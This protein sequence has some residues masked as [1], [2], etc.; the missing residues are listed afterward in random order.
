MLLTHSACVMHASCMPLQ[1]LEQHQL[2]VLRTELGS[3][4]EK[5]SSLADAYSTLRGALVSIHQALSPQV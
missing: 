1:E 5:L 4:Q 3:S 2:Q